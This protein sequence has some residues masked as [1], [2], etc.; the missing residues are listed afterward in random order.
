MW[1]KLKTQYN[2]TVNGKTRRFM[3]GDWV[4]IGTQTAHRLISQGLAEKPG[5]SV[6]NLLIDNTS[7]FVVIGQLTENERVQIKET[8]SHLG[9]SESDDVEMLFSENVIYNRNNSKKL[10]A[11][12]L[13]VGFKWLKH[14]QLIIPIH[15]YE[16]LAIHLGNDEDRKIVKSVIRE[17]RVPVYNTNFMFIR[18]SEATRDL[19]NRWKYYRDELGISDDKLSFLCALYETKPLYLATPVT[20]GT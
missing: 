1:I 8:L 5:E 17:L 2:M 15:S 9:I 20:W 12:L 10:R 3:P 19:I 13:P 11:E 4:D 6:F 7:G 14:F 18:R 16:E